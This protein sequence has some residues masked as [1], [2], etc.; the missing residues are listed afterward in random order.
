[1]I[2]GQDMSEV[3]AAD[4]DKIRKMLTDAATQGT[5][6]VKSA[7]VYVIS[8]VQFIPKPLAELAA[9]LM[10]DHILRPAAAELAPLVQPRIDDTC[11]AWSGTLRERLAKMPSPEPATAG[12]GTRAASAPPPDLSPIVVQLTQAAE[13]HNQAAVSQSL[14]YLRDGMDA[15]APLPFA[16]AYR[17]IDALCKSGAL[18]GHLLQSGPDPNPSIV[19]ASAILVGK[20]PLDTITLAKTLE[21]LQDALRNPGASVDV[22]VAERLLLQLRSARLFDQLANLAD[23][24]LTRGNDTAAIRKLYAQALIDGGRIAAAEDILQAALAQP[25]IGADERDDMVGLLGRVH[26]QIY[27]DHVN[28]VGGESAIMRHRFASHLQE[29]VRQYASAYNAEQP[30]RNFWHG[31]N[32][33]A[34]AKRAEADGIALNPPI[35]ANQ[36]AQRMIEA[37]EPQSSAAGD[38]WILGTVA[39]AYVALA[40]YDKAGEYFKAFAQHPK[41]DEFQLN[42]TIRQL[43]EVWRIKAGPDDAGRMLIAL[44]TV[45]ASRADGFVSVTAEERHELA[46]LETNVPGGEFVK[47]DL[48]RKIVQHGAGVAAIRNKNLTTIGTGFL[49]NATDLVDDGADD[50]LW[51]LT[52]A[53]VV[54]C[55]KTEKAPEIGALAPDD[56]RIFFEDEQRAPV[57]YLLHPDVVFYSP[58]TELD[59]TILRFKDKSPAAKALPLKPKPQLRVEDSSQH[60]PGSP[61]AVLGHPLGGDLAISLLGTFQ[62]TKGTL[63]DFGPR[64]ATLQEPI[65]MHYRTPTEPGNSGS[66]VFETNSWTVAGLHHAGFDP[67]TGRNCL[68]GRPGKNLANEG[69]YI[70]SIKA[71]LRLNRASSSPRRSFWRR[72][73]S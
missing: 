29:S 6:K 17:V 16:D 67:A 28:A 36:L 20:R 15:G 3:D 47:V 73:N 12:G 26:K 25:A 1:M 60:Q 5:D 46:K 23:R 71:A 63:I 45:L 34:L 42:G 51:L 38:A 62:G 24:L 33:I 70:E 32:V 58:P 35:D 59:A 56:A 65:F 64:S 10:V 19:A 40:K 31:I 27:L 50:E 44:K 66:P 21:S 37:L 30:A 13:D 55:P 39:Q 18:E 41:V 48:L 72:A 7:L 69:I 68:R 22:K 54:Y 53:H 2:C 57:P 52:N 11:R 9:G 61:L 14:F 43:E 8:C 49:V 4:R